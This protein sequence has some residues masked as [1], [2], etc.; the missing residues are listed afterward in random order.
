[1][2]ASDECAGCRDFR[3]NKIHNIIVHL[4]KF[5]A[6]SV[7]ICLG[8]DDCYLSSVPLFFQR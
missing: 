3:T 4:L 6:D 8:T 7:A 5:N 2:L 1:M